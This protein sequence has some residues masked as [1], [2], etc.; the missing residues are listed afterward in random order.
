MLF[1]G[2][3]AGKLFAQGMDALWPQLASNPAAYSMAGMG[4]FLANGQARGYVCE[5]SG[6]LFRLPDLGVIGSNGLANP[7][8][9]LTPSATG[10]RP[11]LCH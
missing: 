4:A 9:F 6:V 8:D 3:A 10:R 1:V 11:G 7:R 2:S 5:N